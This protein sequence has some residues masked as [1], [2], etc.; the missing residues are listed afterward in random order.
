MH[1]Y[2]AKGV[3]SGGPEG[4]TPPYEKVVYFFP[5]VIFPVC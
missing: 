1:T 2:A 3:A 4:P 5:I